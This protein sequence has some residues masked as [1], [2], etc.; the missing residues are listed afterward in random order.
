MLLRPPP[1]PNRACLRPGPVGQPSAP[2][3]RE[4]IWAAKGGEDRVVGASF[5]PDSTVVA[6]TRGR[7]FEVYDTRSY[8]VLAAPE[9]VAGTKAVAFCGDERLAVGT[10]DGKVLMYDTRTWE[11]LPQPAV[12]AHDG[13]VEGLHWWGGKL[14]SA[15]ADNRAALWAEIGGEPHSLAGHSGTVT[16]AAISPDSALVATASDDSKLKLWS[17]STGAFIRTCEGHSGNVECVAWSPDGELFASG[18]GDDDVRLWDREGNSQVVTGHS[19]RVRS[20][21]WNRAVPGLLVTAGS[22]HSIRIWTVSG[23]GPAIAP[24]AA[25][26]GM[27]A[28]EGATSGAATLLPAWW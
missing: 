24:D 1:S 3:H 20:C 17:A 28:A 14:V 27:A 22:D 19:N 5:S 9:V 25:P 10:G 7:H 4:L 8:E 16:D 12:Q 13:S 11:P 26:S 23:V 6:G 18:S 2:T 15:G 21:D